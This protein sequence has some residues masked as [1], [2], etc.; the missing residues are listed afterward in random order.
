M[1]IADGVAQFV[2]LFIN[3]AG[4]PYYFSF[5]AHDLD[6]DNE[7]EGGATVRMREMTVSVG[8]AD[9]LVFLKELPDECDGGKA[10]TQQSPR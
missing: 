7:L 8:A 2:G 1:A 10:C 4:G 9:A 5:T 3:E 6:D